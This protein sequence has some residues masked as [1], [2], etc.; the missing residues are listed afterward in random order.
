MQPPT[1]PPRL[2]PHDHW[3]RLTS[4]S[5]ALL[6]AFSSLLTST[7]GLLSTSK[8]SSSSVS[9]PDF[10]SKISLYSFSTRHSGCNCTL[11]LASSWFTTV[12]HGL[13]KTKWIQTVFSPSYSK[14]FHLSRRVPNRKTV[15]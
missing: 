10:S 8:S 12:H 1:V 14:I 5:S 13:W 15:L 4:S 7:P 3:T 2:V 11:L 6:I 9:F